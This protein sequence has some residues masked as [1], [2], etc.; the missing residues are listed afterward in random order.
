MLSDR[1]FYAYAT[2]CSFF[3]NA[4]F[5]ISLL[6]FVLMFYFVLKLL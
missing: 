5:S 4:G 3:R 6:I 2:D 1:P